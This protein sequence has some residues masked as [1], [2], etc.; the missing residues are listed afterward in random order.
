ML[1][2]VEGLFNAFPDDQVYYIT[3]DELV[4]DNRADAEKHCK[5]L[6]ETS[7]A[8]ISREQVNYLNGH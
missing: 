4:F 3:A 7:M 8:I 2:L 1:A 6:E 5:T